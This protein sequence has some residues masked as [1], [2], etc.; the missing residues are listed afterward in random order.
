M[1][2]RHGGSL[3]KKRQ[4]FGPPQLVSHDWRLVCAIAVDLKDILRQIETDDGNLFH[5]TAPLLAVRKQPTIFLSPE[6]GPFHIINIADVQFGWQPRL[7]MSQALSILFLFEAAVST[8]PAQPVCQ[9]QHQTT[10]QVRHMLRSSP[11]VRNF[12]E[13][14]SGIS[15]FWLASERTLWWFT[16]PSHPAFPTILC[17]TFGQPVQVKC[18]KDQAAC[19]KLA[20]ELGKAKF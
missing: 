1:P 6:A 7:M 20:T 4:H 5:G 11:D 14:G 10:A 13:H 8:Q 15:T 18:G 9:L 2:T 3:A 12:P 19:H 17:R 16:E